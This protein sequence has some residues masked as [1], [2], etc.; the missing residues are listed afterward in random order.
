MLRLYSIGGK[1]KVESTGKMT[2]MGKKKNN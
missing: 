2:V 1:C